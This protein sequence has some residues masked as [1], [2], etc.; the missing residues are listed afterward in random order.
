MQV[1]Y[2]F[3][4]TQKNSLYVVAKVIMVLYYVVPGGW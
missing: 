1:I 4:I 3:L 2:E